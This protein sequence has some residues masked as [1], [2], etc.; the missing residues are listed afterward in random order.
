MV[1]VRCRVGHNEI[2]RRGYAEWQVSQ[3]AAVLLL[4]V[5]FAPLIMVAGEPLRRYVLARPPARPARLVPHSAAVPAGHPGGDHLARPR[6][7]CAGF[8]APTQVLAA[9][10]QQPA[11]DRA[12]GSR[13]VAAGPG[14]PIRPPGLAWPSGRR[15]AGAT[16]AETRPARRFSGAGRTA[17]RA[18]P[19]APA[20]HGRAQTGPPR[21]PRRATA[22]A[23]RRPQTPQRSSA[24][25]V[26]RLTELHAVLV[27][28]TGA[29][30]AGTMRQCRR[31]VPLRGSI[32]LWPS[33]HR[34]ASYGCHSGW[35][36]VP[37]Y[38]RGCGSGWSAQGGLS[39][40]WAAERRLLPA[41]RCSG[42]VVALVNRSAAVLAKERPQSRRAGARAPASRGNR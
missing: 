40:R 28:N 7:D 19:C 35:L 6:G 24:Q 4:T 30:G 21:G 42:P 23:P 37:A 36:R 16:A 18:G 2:M 20:R 10:G 9:C 15:G 14:Q 31:S 13:P 39:P 8:L 11:M 41:S 33:P 17:R 38:R 5:A 26:D 3:S 22:A 32:D 27:R 25:P 29:S 1:S 12:D 34:S